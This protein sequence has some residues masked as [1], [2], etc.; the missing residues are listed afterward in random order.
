MKKRNRNLLILISV[1]IVFV[2]YVLLVFASIWTDGN[3]FGKIFGFVIRPSAPHSTA[4]LDS[5]FIVVREPLGDFPSGQVIF[6]KIKNDGKPARVYTV[7][8]CSSYVILPSKTGEQFCFPDGMNGEV[9]VLKNGKL[10]RYKIGGGTVRENIVSVN[11]RIFILSGLKSELT[12]CDKDM[13]ILKT[14]SLH[15]IVPQG[16]VGL[17]MYKYEGELW[18]MG[19]GDDFG[20]TNFDRIFAEINPDTLKAVK[21]VRF[22]YVLNIGGDLRRTVKFDGVVYVLGEDFKLKPNGDGE[23]HDVIYALS[24]LPKPVYVSPVYNTITSTPMSK[25]KYSP[26][27]KYLF[28]IEGLVPIHPDKKEFLLICR[29]R[30][31]LT[32]SGKIK[33][34]L[35]GFSVKYYLYNTTEK[36]FYEVPEKIYDGEIFDCNPGVYCKG[37][38]Y[39]G[40]PKYLLE[41][42]NGKFEIVDRY[43]GNFDSPFMSRTKDL[44]N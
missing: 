30:F 29:S 25:T 32:Q 2:A 41:F 7:K 17:Y 28:G 22:P 44:E 43:R 42:K 20:R 33:S 26:P 40:T 15:D 12:V 21:T 23:G 16:F 9:T 10:K 1:I 19:S 38:I 35:P 13:R 18:I 11:G 37:H 14:A 8:H 6:Y 36:K 31:A 4:Y 34:A 5:D 3:P 27:E 39:I 24:P